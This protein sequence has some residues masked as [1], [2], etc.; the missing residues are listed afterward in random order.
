[1]LWLLQH[2]RK[3]DEPSGRVKRVKESDLT[4]GDTTSELYQDYKQWIFLRDSIQRSILSGGRNTAYQHNANLN[5]TVPINKI[6]TFN[7]INATVRYSANYQWN[8]MSLGALDS[9]GNTI[10]NSNNTQYNTTLNM[11]TL[12]NKWKYY[13]KISTPKKPLTAK[14]PANKMDDPEY[15][16]DKS[17]SL[18]RVYNKTKLKLKDIE[19]EALKKEIKYLDHRADSIEKANKPPVPWMESIVKAILGVKNV[20]LTLGS[21]EGTLLPGYIP[22]TQ[23]LGTMQNTSTGNLLA[24]GYDF[25]FGQQI[26]IAKRAAENDWLVKSASLNNQYTR[27]SNNTFSARATYE[28]FKDFR[29]Q[30][31]ANKTD[32]VNNAE[33]FRYNKQVGEF[34]SQNPQTTGNYSVSFISIRSAFERSNDTNFTSKVFTQFL[35]NRKVISSRLANQNS[36]TVPDSGFDGY[37]LTNQDVVI[38]AFLSAYSGKNPNDVFLGAFP[39]IPLPNWT[40]NY[41]GLSKIEKFKK[42]FKSVTVSHGYKSTYTVSSY[43]TNL[44]FVEG[45]NKRDIRGNYITPKV[46]NALSIAESFSPLLGVDLQW[47]NRL[48]TK[49]EYKKDR[50]LNLSL[51]NIQLTEMQGQELTTGLGYIFK[52][53]VVPVKVGG[54]LRKF[55]SDLTIRSDVSVRTN[56]T[57]VRRSYDNSNQA[58]MGQRTVTLKN[59]VNYQVTSRVTV[60]LFLDVVMNKPFVSTSFPTSNTNGGVSIRFTLGS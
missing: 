27:T 48:T 42:Y 47:Q 16:R 59:S 33:F 26:D 39:K 30:L 18:Q 45:A 37:F 6:P 46:I 13:K 41:D 55:K 10:Q 20:N 11:N 4:P 7:W 28:P 12:Y 19:K 15:L 44:E 29:V 3:I 8:A 14:K 23:Y 38:P 60:R 31:T 2:T 56:K 57:I 21:T 25:V 54:S 53:V 35:E 43:T 40:I 9:L 17:D 50:T 22:K 58:T 1:M 52:D 5:W 32:A 34:Q 24:P 36:A 49:L 51:S